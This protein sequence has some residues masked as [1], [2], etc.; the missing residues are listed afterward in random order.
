MPFCYSENND[1][2]NGIVKQIFCHEY[3]Q[4]S[5]TLIT[6]DF[7]GILHSQMEQCFLK[8]TIPLE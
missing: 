2:Y 5:D 7:K 6:S 4:W 1:L 3:L 8:F